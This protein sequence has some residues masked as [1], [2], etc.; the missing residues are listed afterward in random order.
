ML[1]IK[2]PSVTVTGSSVD[3]MEVPISR[4]AELSDRCSS[5]KIQTKNGTAVAGTGYVPPPAARRDSLSAK[6][7]R[8]L[9]QRSQGACQTYCSKPFRCRPAGRRRRGPL[10]RPSPIKQASTPA[11][12]P[13]GDGG[14]HERRRPARPHRREQWLEHG[15]GAAEHDGTARPR[16]ASPPSRPSPPATSPSR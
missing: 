12:T 8:E 16:P 6:R 13:F 10:L 1:M 3:H 5:F 9:R 4:N 14:G 7:A 15:V 11:R 2:P